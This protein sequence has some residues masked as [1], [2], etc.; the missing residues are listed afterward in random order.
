[1]L[2]DAFGID[3]GDL[4]LK[5]DAPLNAYRVASGDKLLMKNKC[6]PL[7]ILGQLGIAGCWSA[8][9][10]L[11]CRNGYRTGA[12]VDR[13]SVN[14]T[15]N[16]RFT[17]G[18]QRSGQADE[19]VHTTTGR[20]G[21]VERHTHEIRPCVGIGI[22]TRFCEHEG[23]EA[24]ARRSGSCGTRG[25]CAAGSRGSR[26]AGS[27]GGAREANRPV[28]PAMAALAALTLF[29]LGT[30]TPVSTVLTVLTVFAA[31]AALAIVF[32][33]LLTIAHPGLR[34]DFS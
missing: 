33:L 16:S 7:K 30:I 17:C 8:A 11:S 10:G 18:G 13:D 27:S 9:C 19:D 14:D 26:D 23:V 6:V 12:A 29:A 4:P 20:I 5:L 34:Q 24:L 2:S 28:V 32:A 1:M 22:C 25:S 31:F 15:S 3:A 21:D